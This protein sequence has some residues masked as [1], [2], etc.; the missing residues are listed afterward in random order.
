V[1]CEGPRYVIRPMTLLHCAR[2]SRRCARCRE[3]VEQG[4]R[5]QLLDTLPDEHPEAARPVIQVD[6]AWRTYDVERVFADRVEAEA[7]ARANDGVRFE[8]A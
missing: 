4:P 2:G 1:T 7:Y 6:G 5:W 3:L 8:E